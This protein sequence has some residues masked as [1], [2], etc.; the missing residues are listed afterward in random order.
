MTVKTAVIQAGGK[1]TRIS[2]LT[3]DAIPKPMLPLNGI[4]IVE[5]QILTLKRE[6]ISDF[7]IIIGHLGNVIKTHLGDG[8][9]L[10]VQIDYFQ[11]T[12]PLGSGGALLYVVD[13]INQPFI[14]LNG[15]LLF[16][17]Y[18]KKMISFH[19]ENKAEITLLVHPNSH[20]YDSDL[21]QTNENS[22]I[23]GIVRGADGWYENMVNA[24]IAIIEPACF[25]EFEKGQN[26]SFEHEMVLPLIRCGKDIYA[27]HTTEYVFDVGT[28]SRLC[29]AERDLNADLPWKRNLRNP[30]KA[31]FIDRDGTINIPNDFIYTPE[32]FEL[33][34][35]SATAINKLNNSGYLTFCITNQPSVARGLC[36]ENDIKLIHRKMQTLLGSQG[37]Y[38]DGIAYC[39]H[40]PDSGYPEERREYKIQCEC[41]KPGTKLVREFADRFH[42]DLASSWFIG[43]S[44]R[45]M[46]CGQAAGMKTIRVDNKTTLP[47]AVDIILY[48][49]HS[50]RFC[51]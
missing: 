30:Q 37:A 29:R 21:V 16:D 23:L 45:D 24:G 38:L 9:Q 36:D 10:G 28:E 26:L 5:R 17:I 11:E 40:H 47:D 4:P 7:V 51:D 27:Y 22:K 6:G 48:Q 44:D 13:R 46:L 15:D 25:S 19:I 39:P 12:E 20:P 2:G 32:M 43:D 34:P 8:K 50:N 33:F 42:I 18:A 3:N 35:Y 49:S 31:V 41:R 1:G 14:F